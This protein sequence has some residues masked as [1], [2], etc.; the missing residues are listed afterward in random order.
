MD[1]RYSYARQERLFVPSIQQYMWRFNTETTVVCLQ[2]LRR[3][4]KRQV[5]INEGLKYRAHSWNCN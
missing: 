5:H 4:F 2:A 1:I 3:G